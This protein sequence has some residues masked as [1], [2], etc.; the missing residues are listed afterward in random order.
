M[1][2]YWA[3][4]YQR[5]IL[6]K[7]DFRVLVWSVQHLTVV[8][9]STDWYWLDN[10]SYR[11][12]QE[13]CWIDIDMFSL[14]FQ[15]LYAMFYHLGLQLIIDCELLVL[16]IFELTILIYAIAL[17]V[18]MIPGKFMKFRDTLVDIKILNLVI[19]MPA[20]GVRTT[21]VAVVATK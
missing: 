12:V 9:D 13:W 4:I 18:N 6:G 7:Y 5:G 11:K 10:K 2:I 20:D 15:M 8:P 14:P 1:L 16:L 21:N 19:I 17:C 3:H